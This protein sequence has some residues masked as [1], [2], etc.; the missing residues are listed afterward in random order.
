LIN[1]E[2]NLNNEVARTE[3]TGSFDTDSTTVIVPGQKTREPTG[4]SFF[5]ALK[6][7]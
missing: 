7:N 3:R 6:N 1:K 5:E 4:K 2:N